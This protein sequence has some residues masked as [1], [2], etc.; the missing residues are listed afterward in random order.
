MQQENSTCAKGVS[1]GFFAAVVPIGAT[2]SVAG[3]GAYFFDLEASQGLTPEGTP[4][5][6]LFK[7]YAPPRSPLVCQ[8]VRQRA[9]A[10]HRCVRPPSSAEPGPEPAAFALMLA[11]LGVSSALPRWSRCGSRG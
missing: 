10:A 6:Q 11:G 3:N 9:S 7:T 8:T 5:V 2:A 4:S 1:Q